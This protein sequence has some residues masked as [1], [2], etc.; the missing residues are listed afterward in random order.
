MQSDDYVRGRDLARTF[1]DAQHGDELE[2]AIPASLSDLE[3][4]RMRPSMDIE[5]VIPEEDDEGINDELKEPSLW[6]MIRTNTCCWKHRY[7]KAPRRKA[8]GS[9]LFVLKWVLWGITSLSHL[10][11][12]I[13]CIGATMQQKTVRKALPSTFALL[14]PPDYVKSAMCAWDKASPTGDI[15]T[16][17]S[18]DAV[19]EA[20]YTVIHCGACGACSNWNDLRLQW[21]TRSNL[22]QLGQTCVQKKFFGG[23]T[24]A[25]QDCNEELIGFTEECS[26][27]WT[28]DQMCASTQCLF[29][30]LQ[31]LVVN[32]VSNFNVDPNDI[33]TTTCDEALCG[34]EFVPCSGATRR[35]MNIVS[36]IPRPKDQQC[37]VANENW[38]VIFDHP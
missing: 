34:P 19:A 30:Y 3:V 22:A 26:E 11:F 20:N 4:L 18:P 29:I 8:W 35:R 24:E 37:T 23:G 25:V 7:Y 2:P 36:D 12:L 5:D 10:L 13:I 1:A 9:V 28:V 38:P 31:S 17:E 33:T 15:R 6:F 16:F 14:Y 32:Q 27:C 21:T